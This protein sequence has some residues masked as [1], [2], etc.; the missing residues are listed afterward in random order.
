MAEFSHN[1]ATHSAINKLSFSLIL[2]YE[3]RSYPLIRKTFIPTL[4]TCLGELEESR[5][6]ALAAHEKAWR[7]MKEQT[8]SKFYPWK[9]GDEVWLEGKNL[10]LCYL[11]KKLTPR[12]EGPFEITQIIS[13]ITYKLWLP[14]NW[15]IHDVFHT[16]L[17]SSYRET[18]EHRPNFSNPPPDLIG[19]EEEYKIDKILSYCRTWGQR[20]YLVSWKGYSVAENMW[21][22]EGNLQHAQ[23][24]LK[25]YKL[26]CPKDF[27][28]SAWVSITMSIPSV[29]IG[30]LNCPPIYAH[31]LPLVQ[32]RILFTSLL[33]NLV[34]T[35]M[36]ERHRGFTNPTMIKLCHLFCIYCTICLI[37][38][39]L[40]PTDV[41]PVYA[42]TMQTAITEACTSTLDF[43][44][45]EGFA[46][47]V[48]D[49]PRMVVSPILAPFL[50]GML[51]VDHHLYFNNVAIPNPPLWSSALSP[52]IPILPS[53]SD[54]ENTPSTIINSGTPPVRAASVDSTFSLSSYQSV[55]AQLPLSQVTTPSNPHCLCCF[56]QTILQGGLIFQNARSF[57]AQGARL[58]RAI[59]LDTEVMA[60]AA[61][62]AGT[63]E[64]PIDVDAPAHNNPAPHPPTPGP[65]YGPNLPCFQCQSRDHIRKNWPD[66]CCPYC[67]QS[68]QSGSIGYIERR[69]ISLPAA[70][71]MMIGIIMMSL[72]T[73]DMLET[74][75]VTQG[76]KGDSIMVFLSFLPLHY[77]L[78]ISPST[79]GHNIA[80]LLIW[81]ILTC[82][83]SDFL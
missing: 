24:L 67:N 3:P 41:P 34:A 16:S 62:A 9:S 17:L 4:E 13:P 7:T 57:N 58:V 79:Y 19:G 72:R 75:L 22:L 21:E 28:P 46:Y 32:R 33:Q 83:I 8:S 68:V 59:I 30:T 42:A 82:L 74:E 14:P 25:A 64:D 76:N 49:L 56:Q 10:K 80:W 27:F 65:I 1:S 66:Y 45:E 54:R 55:L 20:Q 73:K 69:N 70:L 2:R 23:I 26:Q 29:P 40:C 52:T 48:N 6:K 15:K 61:N 77:G 11:S 44:Y 12:R 36:I 5:K 78:T 18:L 60:A 37:H 51:E 63:K 47:I 31:C 50:Q 35:L 43:L 53:P 81:L 71:L 39:C 38:T